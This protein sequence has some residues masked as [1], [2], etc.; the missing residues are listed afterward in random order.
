MYEFK[1]PDVGEGVH[2]GKILQLKVN[3]GDKISE[4]EIFAIV[5]TDKV[6]AEIPSS[7]TGILSKFSLAEGQIIEVGQTLAFIETTLDQSKTTIKN[8]SDDNAGVVG[9]L[10]TASN[11]VLPASSEGILDKSLNSIGLNENN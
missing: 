3:P 9:Q 6:D 10:E 7:K 11:I 2:E 1:F 5:V 4:G 8:I